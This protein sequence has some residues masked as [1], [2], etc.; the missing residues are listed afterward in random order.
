AVSVTLYT[1]NV[2][3]KTCDSIAESFKLP[4]LGE[5]PPAKNIA[6]PVYEEIGGDKTAKYTVA[7]GT[8]H[9]K[10][11]SQ[12]EMYI[13]RQIEG[14]ATGLD[15]LSYVEDEAGTVRLESWSHIENS[16][17]RGFMYTYYDR[18][19][20]M[21]TYDNNPQIFETLTK[22]VIKEEGKTV[23]SLKTGSAETARLL[24]IPLDLYRDNAEGLLGLKTA[25]STD[26]HVKSILEQVMP[27]EKVAGVTVEKKEGNVN[28]KFGEGAELNPTELSKEAAV[29]FSLASDVE[30]VTAVAAD[31]T[32][33]E[34]KRDTVMKD[35]ATPV[36]EITRSPEDFA[37][38][39]ENMD[40]IQPAVP[41]KEEKPAGDGVPSGTVVYSDSIYISSS[42]LVTHPTTGEKV[43]IGP[44]AQKKGYGHLLDKSIQCTIRKSG[45]GYIATATCGG[46]VIASYPL[47]S[48]AAV[49]S[50]IRTIQSY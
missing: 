17:N 49:R 42:M 28:L 39:A 38:F 30:T 34:L 21:F 23:Y 2:R 10:N 8:V 4:E 19:D 14:Q 50:A 48:E 45:S 35:V 9:A 22:E 31:G 6:V 29:L 13:R 20:G 36:E 15:V 44:Y 26:A 24:E 27:E 40:S 32:K 25:E 46:S 11:I 33:Y 5:K 3:M 1:K 47:E 37:K 43:P 16:G 12:L 18:G 41:K 7:D